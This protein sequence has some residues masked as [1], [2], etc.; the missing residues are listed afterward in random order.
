MDIFL[1]V[2]IVF[3][4]S[5]AFYSIHLF[6][7]KKKKLK[8]VICS[9]FILF[10]I[11]AWLYVWFGKGWVASAVYGTT[12]LILGVILSTIALTFDLYDKKK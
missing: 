10:S 2:M 9:V 12:S 3:F 1:L 8:Y 11:C 6:L 7:P 5:V 4:S